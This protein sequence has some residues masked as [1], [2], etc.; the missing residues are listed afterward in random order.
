MVRFLLPLAAKSGR[1]SGQPFSGVIF[2][3]PPYFLGNFARTQY[4]P[5][6]FLLSSFSLLHLRSSSFRNNSSLF[7]TNITP[8]TFSFSLPPLSSPSPYSPSRVTKESKFRENAKKIEDSKTK[9]VPLP[10][11]SR[12]GILSFNNY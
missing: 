2:P 10:S 9:D 7:Y 12:K 4:M 3:S 11:A 1:Y 5:H 6:A 8:P